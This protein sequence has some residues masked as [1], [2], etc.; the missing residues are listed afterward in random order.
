M[1]GK[2]IINGGMEIPVERRGLR[3]TTNYQSLGRFRGDPA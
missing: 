1:R 3:D 2:E